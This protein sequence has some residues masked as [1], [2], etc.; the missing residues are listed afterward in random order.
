[1]LCA[2]VISYQAGLR[3]AFVPCFVLCRLM[4]VAGLWT[5]LPGERLPK[6]RDF[7]CHNFFLYGVHFAF[8]R[9]INKAGARVLPSFAAVSM[10]LYLLMPALVLCIAAMLGRFLR[11]Y[12]P[13]LWNL[14]NG[15]RI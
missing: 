8:V 2:A 9:F 12:A 5:L 13:L 1:M 4:A 7:M 11:R 15:G 6:A 10:I 3:A 14:L